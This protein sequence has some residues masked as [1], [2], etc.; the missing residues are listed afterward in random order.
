[1]PEYNAALPLEFLG[2]SRTLSLAKYQW[3]IR[4]QK[5]HFQTYKYLEN[6]APSHP[7]VGNSEGMM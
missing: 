2:Q 3:S 4:V 7:F 5:G 1:M 6:L